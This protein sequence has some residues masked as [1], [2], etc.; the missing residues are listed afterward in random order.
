MY[1]SIFLPVLIFTLTCSSL[2][3]Q[4]QESAIDLAEEAA[5]RIRAGE[6]ETRRRLAMDR[7]IG[8]GPEVKS[9]VDRLAS[10][11]EPI[12]KEA[13]MTVYAAWRM[14]A[15]LFVPFLKDASYP[16]RK[17]ALE[18]L[19]CAEEIGPLTWESIP[20]LL[21]D[22]FWP[23]RRSAVRALAAWPRAG[24]AAHYLE[25]FKDPEPEV[26]RAAL[27]CM[28]ELIE[29]LSIEALEQASSDLSCSEYRLFMRN[30]LSLVRA[31][32]IAFFQERAEQEGDEEA[33]T[34][35]R[36]ACAAHTRD[37]AARWIPDLV[38]LAVGGKEQV[39]DAACTLLTLAGRKIAGSVRDALHGRDGAP[40]INLSMLLLIFTRALDREAIPYLREWALD[41]TLPEET[42]A[43]CLERL[44]EW[45]I[46]EAAGVF[47]AVAA[48]LDAK[49]ME[50]VLPRTLSFKESP[51]FEYYMPML[52]WFLGESGPE[53]SKKIFGALCLAREPK[54]RFLIDTVRATHDAAL[55]RAYIRHL[56]NAARDS[57]RATVA[58]FLLSELSMRCPAAFE[59]A[60]QLPGV[61]IPELREKAL[62]QIEAY[63]NETTDP[64]EREALLF[65]LVYLKHPKADRFLAD[66]VSRAFDE[67]RTGD[68]EY[69]V[70]H[71]DAVHGPATSALLAR[72]DRS[73]PQSL[74]EMILRTLVRRG[75]LAAAERISTVFASASH[76]YKRS[77]LDDL[78]EV[79]PLAIRC[80]DF[81][82]PILYQDADPDLLAAALR[83]APASL[84]RGEE[85]QLIEL[86][87]LGA[88][89]GMDAMDALY[90]SLA[91]VGTAKSLDYLRERV[92][93]FLAVA[94]GEH[95]AALMELPEA[96]LAQMAALHLAEVNDPEAPDLLA[97]LLF[98]EAFAL[99][100]HRISA[101]WTAESEGGRFGQAHT[102]MR[103]ILKGLLMLD[104]E[105]IEK[106]IRAEV[107]RR[108][109]DG[110]LYECG[111]A[112]FCTLYR[113]LTRKPAAMGRMPGLAKRFADLTLTCAPVLSP[114]DFRVFL[115]RADEA[116]EKNDPAAAADALRFA[117]LTLKFHGVAEEVVRDKLGESDPF[118]GYD[119]LSALASD[120]LLRRAEVLEQS[121]DK[122]RARAAR[123]QARRRSPF[124]TIN[125]R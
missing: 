29:D 8:L 11:P 24:T 48:D 58:T 102:W 90:R 37:V 14:K 57:H 92:R 34:F 80:G 55:R 60:V 6:A 95:S 53:R 84:L 121:G 113:D 105:A 62:E 103:A 54:V 26:R 79:P 43:L 117:Y 87:G 63:L 30:S 64:R 41:E 1:L 118:A 32:N 110:T 19:L 71:L 17:A 67:G 74:R 66:A 28:T 3:A 114:S 23:V 104:D 7:L 16:V 122:D 97:R 4:A 21:D 5:A 39:S 94:K 51:N 119:P 47:M 81:I 108:S 96:Q 35:A 124:N 40:S 12:A 20:P 61:I 70:L 65:A 44:I 107:D 68:V 86:A 89:L 33:R 49:M 45:D 18:G 69:F 72:L 85:A 59:A 9:V 77:L 93:A 100:E 13:A 99:R 38:H 52:M 75:D 88:E 83:A 112:V 101:I 125:S 123:E 46:P 111:D 27:R 78:A 15:N 36:L 116:E 10:S 25:A 31:S 115:D 22:P 2:G 82:T 76:G 109:E 56:A 50:R 120:M 42:R 106:A 91:R 98:I 73:A